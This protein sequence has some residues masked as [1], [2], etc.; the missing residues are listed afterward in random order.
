[1]FKTFFID[2][3]TV[4]AVGDVGIF[5]KSYNLGGTWDARQDWPYMQY[6]SLYFPN[7]NT[8]YV[9]GNGYFGNPSPGIIYKTINGGTNWTNLIP[10]VRPKHFVEMDF[11]DVN[12]GYIIGD[13]RMCVKNK[14]CGN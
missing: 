10:P 1:M 9:C 11:V 8:G 14:Q 5:A 4:Y 13:S 3:N 2:N 6:R 12:S 7:L